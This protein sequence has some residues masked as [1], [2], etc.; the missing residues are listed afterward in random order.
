MPDFTFQPPALV[1]ARSMPPE[2]WF[3]KGFLGTRKIVPRKG[4][5]PGDISGVQGVYGQTAPAKWKEPGSHLIQR[6]RWLSLPGYSLNELA[7]RDDIIF[8]IRNTLKR[9]IGGMDWDIVPDI[10]K[11]KADLKRWQ[12]ITFLQLSMPSL[13][14]KFEPQAVDPAFFM[15][16]SGELREIIRDEF[17]GQIDQTTPG[18]GVEFN[19]DTSM[20]LREFFERCVNYFEVVAE[21]H[22]NAVKRTLERP[23][24]SAESSFRALMNRLVD[25]LTIFDAAALIKNSTL[26]GRP[27]ELYSVPG[28]YMRVYMCDDLSTPQPPFAAYDWFQDAK[29]RAFYNNVEMV[30]LMMNPQRDGYGKPPMEVLLEQMVGSLYGD[31]YLVDQFSNNN[32]P[33]F[34][35]DAGPNISQSERDAMETAW[36]NRVRKGMHRGIFIGAKE[37]VKGFL[38]VPQGSNKDNEILQLM[39]H[40]SARKC[41]AFGLSLNDIGFTEDLHRTTAETQ[42]ELT[43]ARGVI[44]MAKCIEGYI[45]QEYVKGMLWLRDDPQD[46][47]CRDGH[48]VP[49]FPFKD[50]KFAFEQSDDKQ[51]LEDAQR[52]V[53]LID[54]GVITINEVRKE[55][56]LPP[57]EG[58]DVLFT[59]KASSS[60][61]RVEDLMEI[62]LEQQQEQ[63][64]ANAPDGGEGGGEGGDGPPKPPGANETKPPQPDNSE[65][66]EV[67]KA[68][69]LERRLRKLRD[70][71]VS[72]L[73]PGE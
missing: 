26:D 7:N 57:R 44:S 50:V 56:G 69:G 49:C 45:N 38:P 5:S 66:A 1:T 21:G 28:E 35:F 40:W 17:S 15:A 24:P 9:A 53:T 20:R 3:K 51:Q 23:N 60:I 31:A 16:A 8:S 32:M 34:V 65:D 22:I 61:T 18:S 2:P 19:P 59:A 4:A 13:P 30:Y 55:L 33:F 11:I 67:E 68:K 14:L 43:Q 39:Q 54:A 10:D 73:R 62:S 27:G 70:D 25:D 46:P 42:A 12:Q 48:S 71:L 63:A 6:Q 47:E 29:I 36:D 37:G 58:G 41:A 64:K 52:A 72:E